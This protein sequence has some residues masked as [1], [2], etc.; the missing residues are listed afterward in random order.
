MCSSQ[1]TDL[2]S[3]ER[4]EATNTH[5][6]KDC[7][8]PAGKLPRAWANARGYARLDVRLDTTEEQRLTRLL[9]PRE[10]LGAELTWVLGTGRVG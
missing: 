1:E 9:Y 7:T 4:R 5:K 6:E 8:T 10:A 2:H 3:N